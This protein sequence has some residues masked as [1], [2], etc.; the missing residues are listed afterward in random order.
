M[1]MALGPNDLLKLQPCAMRIVMLEQPRDVLQ[2]LEH[3]KE[4]THY[5]LLRLMS[6]EGMT[7]AP[8]TATT[9]VITVTIRPSFLGGMKEGR[10]PPAS[11]RFC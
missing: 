1:P 11:I 10:S 8:R 4:L 6:R 2:K 9:I 7:P 5:L 3:L